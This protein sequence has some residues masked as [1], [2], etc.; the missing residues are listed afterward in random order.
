MVMQP[1]IK[2]T[3]IGQIGLSSSL[4][5]PTIKK[6]WC[7]CIDIYFSLV[8]LLETWHDKANLPNLSALTGY[9]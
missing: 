5:R 2:H 4:H 1:V 9:G 6:N 3:E 8:K 7:N